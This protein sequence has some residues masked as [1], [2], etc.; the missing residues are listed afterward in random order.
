[1][2]T[3]QHIYIDPIPA[4]AARKLL[5]Q[6]VDILIS[7]QKAVAVDLYHMVI[8]TFA[9]NTSA[10]DVKALG[11]IG[12]ISLS[13]E[14]KATHRQKLCV[15][16]SARKSASDAEYGGIAY[17]E[18]TALVFI[19]GIAHSSLGIDC[20]SNISVAEKRRRVVL[21]SLAA[22][23]G[24]HIKISRFYSLYHKFIIFFESLIYKNRTLSIDNHAL[25]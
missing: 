4:V 17:F 3:R 15:F 20:K 2:I 12:Q 23:I 11:K 24:F 9:E 25:L 10:F 14:H 13:A 18:I 1:M 21:S 22:M 19:R 7:A 5:F 6:E 16:V 8:S